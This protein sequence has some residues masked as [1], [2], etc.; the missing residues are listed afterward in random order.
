MSAET[1]ISVATGT[2]PVRLR[3]VAGVR[4]PVLAAL[5]FCLVLAAAPAVSDSPEV[6]VEGLTGEPR[7]NVLAALALVQPVGALIDAAALEDHQTASVP[8]VRQA[9]QP[10]GYYRPRIAVELVEAPGPETGRTLRYRIDPGP[11]VPLER[12]D[13]TLSGAGAGDEALVAAVDALPLR[14]AAHLDHR[15]YE[16]AKRELLQVAKDRGYRDANFARHRVEVDL[17]RYAARI[18]LRLDSGPRYVFGPVEF[19][20]DTF[21]P[22]YLERYLL[23]RPGQPFDSELVTRQRIA[24][25][26]SGHFQEVSVQL[27]EPDAD[28]EPAIP[29][30][31]R[32]VPY[33]PSRYRGRVGWGTE[34]GVGLQLDWAR[35][36]IGD[37][38]HSFNL[39]GTAVEQRNRLAG[40]FRYT[41]PLRPLTGRR[42][43]FIARHES[44]DLSF[45]DVDL[46]EGGET[47]IAT[48][49][50]SALW[51]DG[52]RP[53]GDFTLSSAAGLTYLGESYD[54]FEVVFGSFPEED[55]QAIRDFIGPEGLDTLA[56]EFE[57][58]VASLRISLRRADDRIDIGRGDFLDL[59]LLGADDA[60]GSN[61]TFWQARFSSWHIRPLGESNRLLLRSALGYSDAESRELFG[62]SFNRM[63]EFYEFRAGGARS[64]RGYGWETL[65]PEDA[66]TGAR[67]QAILSLEYEHEVVP[68]WAAAVFLD[69]GNAFNDWDD[70]D[71]KLGAGFGLRWRS[72]VGMARID[73]GFPLDDADDA[74]QIY[75]TVG[76]EF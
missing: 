33:P 69:A 35:R 9:L 32:L 48:N 67:H 58:L 34:T 21:D 23:V 30:R 42:L 15:D 27:G 56:P 18:Q 46:D 49:L 44:K 16:A 3:G 60:V 53:L 39:G 2:E 51:R 4:R 11:P 17:Q 29:L 24:L 1:A 52:A 41:I 26:R 76:P 73:L 28:A 63:P 66:I 68:D 61:I 19:L 13:V 74:F 25:S 12:V 10:F 45:E 6:E 54:V 5:A 43:E 31:I 37:A 14:R 75:I 7:A 40:D 8:A 22:A 50:V 65:Y 47:R 62:V 38:G 59:Q 70:I 57:A 71:P 64:V 55:Q 72:P 36:Y 20:Q